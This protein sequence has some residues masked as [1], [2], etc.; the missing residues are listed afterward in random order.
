MTPLGY[1]ITWTAYGTWLPGDARGW[2]ARGKPWVQEPDASR[3]EEAR[4]IMS[5]DVVSLT[6]E[7]RQVIEETV[8]SHCAVRGW[9]LHAVNARTTHVHVVVTA[10]NNRPDKVMDQLK[11]WCSRRLNEQVGEKRRWWTY[12]GS[13]KWIN[14]EEYLASAIQYVLERQ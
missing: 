5:S 14:D 10:N 7:Q 8:R 3:E 6:P 13:T 11:S 4:R 1:F 9:L 2:V 12:H